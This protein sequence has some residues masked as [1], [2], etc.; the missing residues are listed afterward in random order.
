MQLI[1]QCVVYIVLPAAI[2]FHS[3]IST[4]RS[5]RLSD[6]GVELFMPHRYAHMLQV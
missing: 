1:M 4:N 6:I 2:L 3:Y 5:L